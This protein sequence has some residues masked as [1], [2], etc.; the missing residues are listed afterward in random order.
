MNFYKSILYIISLVML[1][2]RLNFMVNLTFLFLE[3]V[4]A[5]GSA[6]IIVCYFVYDRLGCRQLTFRLKFIL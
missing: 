6:I 1:T 5:L 2:Y 4:A 3:P